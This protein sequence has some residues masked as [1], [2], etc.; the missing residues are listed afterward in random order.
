MSKA[1]QVLGLCRFSFPGNLE[2]FQTR[3]ETMEARKAAL[4]DPKRLD[5]RFVWFEHVWL[6]SM[7]GQTD[8]S[9]I[10]IVLLGD[11]FPEPYRSRIQDLLSPHRQ[12]VP[13]F[14][15]TGN[16]RE[17]Y[18]AVLQRFRDPGAQVVAEFRLDD[19]DGVAKNFVEDLRHK[20]DWVK[21]SVQ[22]RARTAVDYPRGIVVDAALDGLT[23]HPRVVPHWAPGM[24][25][26]LRPDDEECCMDFPHHKI[27]W[28]MPVL[29]LPHQIMFVRGRH[30]T[31]DSPIPLNEG[32]SFK[33][34]GDGVEDRLKARFG[35]D[36]DAFA[37]AWSMVAS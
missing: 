23:Y 26:F 27:W 15:A 33:I 16:H 17:I 19:D 14:H 10:C 3:H 9:F 8:N 29:S 34:G 35:I 22:A 5:Q 13:V 25:V 32:L 28:R 24:A 6:P 20:W 30:S 4:Y 11:D 1:V 2:S 12:L 18:R 21:P 37:A 7:L 31:N 36:A